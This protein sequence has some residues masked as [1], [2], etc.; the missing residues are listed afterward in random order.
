M[1]KLVCVIVVLIGFLQS[2]KKECIE[3]KS[4]LA[5]SSKGCFKVVKFED[6]IQQSG[7][8]DSVGTLYGFGELKDYRCNTHFYL[9]DTS[10]YQ[11]VFNYYKDNIKQKDF[12]QTIQIEFKNDTIFQNNKPLYLQKFIGNNL[13]F[14]TFNNQRFY[15]V[16]I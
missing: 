11:R 8:I 14:E 15:L 1:K 4:F 12:V 3:P 2:C 10:I 5:S 7:Y 16:K 9:D 6:D 13:V